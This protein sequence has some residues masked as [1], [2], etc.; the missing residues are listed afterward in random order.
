MY[1]GLARIEIQLKSKA[2]FV[3]AANTGFLIEGSPLESWQKHG[4]IE[5]AWWA[6]TERVGWYE[7]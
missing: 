7:L 1:S 4:S 2:F 3:K 6:V 5:T